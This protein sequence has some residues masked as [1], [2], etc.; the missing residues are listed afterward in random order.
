MVIHTETQAPVEESIETPLYKW[1]R[2]QNGK[3]ATVRW[4]PGSNQKMEKRNNR[5]Q[6]RGDPVRVT[7]G[8]GQLIKGN[9]KLKW[10]TF[11]ASLPRTCFSKHQLQEKRLSLCFCSVIG[12][13]LEGREWK[14]LLLGSLR[15]REVPLGSSTQNR[16]SLR[17]TFPRSPSLLLLLEQPAEH[18]KNR[19]RDWERRLRARWQSRLLV[20]VSVIKLILYGLM[21]LLHD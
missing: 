16:W 15:D 11:S 19:G 17:S 14:S 9:T 2:W 4:M 12:G 3:G 8:G 1:Y 7:T 5:T 6:E 21:I 18:K 20:L 13:T 10:T